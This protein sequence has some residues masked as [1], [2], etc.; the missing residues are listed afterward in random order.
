MSEK[1]NLGSDTRMGNAANVP[2]VYIRTRNS[3]IFCVVG[4]YLFYLIFRRYIYS[5]RCQ[6]KRQKGDVYYFVFRSKSNI[7][8]RRAFRLLQRQSRRRDVYFSILI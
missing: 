8:A 4:I 6:P 2:C 3:S 7:E 5:N 1:K